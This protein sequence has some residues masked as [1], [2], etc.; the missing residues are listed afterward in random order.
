MDG[1]GV[2]LMLC[3]FSECTQVYVCLYVCMCRCIY[4]YIYI[5][6]IYLHVCI[7]ICICICMEIIQDRPLRHHQRAFEHFPKIPLA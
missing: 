1:G 7:Y 3:L 4:I 2:V 5:F 6:F